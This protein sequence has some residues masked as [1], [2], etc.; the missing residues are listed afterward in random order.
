MAVVLVADNLELLVELHVDL[1]AVV[2][3]DLDLVLA[4]LVV[5][6]GAGDPAPCGVGEGSLACLVARRR[7]RWR[8]PLPSSSGPSSPDEAVSHG[9]SCYGDGTNPQVRRRMRAWWRAFIWILQ[10][11]HR[12]LVIPSC[13]RGA[14]R[15]LTRCRPGSAAGGELDEF[16]GLVAAGDVGL[17]DH[18]NSGGIRLVLDDVGLQWRPVLGDDD[19]G[20]FAGPGSS[21]SLRLR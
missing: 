1:V 11:S 9:Q 13:A 2:E 4:F 5:D 8:C 3:G 21:R 16:D 6:L 12:T 17:V 20:V 19:V 18:A 15:S 10:R 7:R 14:E